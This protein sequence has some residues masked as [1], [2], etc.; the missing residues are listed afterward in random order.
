MPEKAAGF[1]LTPGKEDNEYWC[2]S[3]RKGFRFLIGLYTICND[4]AFVETCFSCIR[5]VFAVGSI[6]KWFCHRANAPM[7]QRPFSILFEPA[8]TLIISAA[9]TA[10]LV[11]RHKEKADVMVVFHVSAFIFQPQKSSMAVF[12]AWHPREDSNL[13]PAA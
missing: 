8:S 1:G 13:R 7:Q 6:I 3:G 10:P 5:S 12:P 4:L 9:I 11:P 2:N